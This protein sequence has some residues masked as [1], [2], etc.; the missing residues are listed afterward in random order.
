MRTEYNKLQP[1]RR[2]VSSFVHRIQEI[3]STIFDGPTP[4]FPSEDQVEE[5][6]NQLQR[7][8]AKLRLTIKRHRTAFTHVQCAVINCRRSQNILTRTNDLMNKEGPVIKSK[9]WEARE[10]FEQSERNL[11]TAL[12]VYPDAR[13]YLPGGEL[14]MNSA[15]QSLIIEGLSNNVYFNQYLRNQIDEARKEIESILRSLTECEAR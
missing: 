9:I 1:D 2:L 10:D 11:Q 12:M 15:K 3:E 5:Q 4:S 8:T 13:K 6:T 14:L 7:N